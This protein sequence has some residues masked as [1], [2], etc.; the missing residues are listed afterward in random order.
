MLS[1]HGIPKKFVG[2]LFLCALFFI[3]PLTRSAAYGAT[4]KGRIAAISAVVSLLLLSDSPLDRVTDKDWDE[5]AVRKVLQTFSYG[6]FP[7]DNQVTLWADMHPRDAINEIMTFDPAN[8]KLSPP[9]F[10]NLH[11]VS[12]G[13][14]EGL[15]RFFSSDDPDNNILPE[16]RESYEV[17]RW[18]APH[19][20]WVMAVN[21]R[22]LNPFRQRIGLWETNYH[23]SVNQEAGVHPFPVIRHYDNVMMAL[24]NSKPY[25][26]VLAQ[27]ALNAAIA[28]QYGHNHNVFFQGEFYGNEDFAREFHQLFFGIL[29]E[30]DH[31]YHELVSIKNTAKALTGM[32]ASWH[33]DEEGGPDVEITF[34]PDFHHTDPLEILH[35]TIS[36]PTAKEKIESLARV[37]I[38][39]QESL[40]NLPVMIVE[41]LGDNN[42]SPEK[43]VELQRFWRSM[44]QKDLLKFLKRYAT[45]K[46]FHSPNRI[47]YHTS[48]D[49]ILYIH[50]QMLLTNAELYNE[51]Y[52]PSWILWEDSIGIFNPDHNVFGHQRG[53]EAYN[54]PAVFKNAY[55][56]STE[57]YWYYGRVSQDDP[58]YLK[59]WGSV[60]PKGSNGIYLVKDVAK[61][62]WQ[63]FVADGWKNFGILEQAHIYPLLAFGQDLG[64]YIDDD[65]PTRVYYAEDFAEP[66][67]PPRL[68]IENAGNWFMDLDSSNPTK[69]ETANERVQQA[70]A[71]IAAT[72]YTFLEEGR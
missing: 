21:T 43:R 47:K 39:D 13:S 68:Q 44:P 58:S 72:P 36:G 28:Y 7:T 9:D 65:D 5:T 25:E 10:D 6:G 64:Y 70:I 27:G 52:V 55:N 29:G 12:D 32:Q 20:T 54:S 66:D 63:R 71:F 18:S 51:L 15:A 24:A 34:V 14:L 17:L 49:R 62:L 53:A 23:M 50:H 38:A 48:I 2:I 40:E 16:R 69:R 19:N 56:L 30:N 31:A 41:N 4:D 67:S 33:P 26:E 3:S 46:M 60:I 45:S 59:E 42:L 11:M 22:G 1:S 37:A 8:I 57:W 35:T 61:W